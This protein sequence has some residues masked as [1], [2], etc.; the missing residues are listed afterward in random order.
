M[1]FLVERKLS[2]YL[3]DKFQ[4]MAEV[5]YHLLSPSSILQSNRPCQL[6]RL[7]IGKYKHSSGRESSIDSVSRIP[8]TVNFTD[9]VGSTCPNERHAHIF[10]VRSPFILRVI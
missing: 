5:G 6:F 8:R 1:C 3:G 10:N 4:V 9:K 2:F 7:F